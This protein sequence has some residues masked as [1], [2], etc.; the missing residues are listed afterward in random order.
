MHFAQDFSPKHN[1]KI[2]IIIYLTK[3]FLKKSFCEGEIYKKSCLIIDFD[4][5][6][7]QHFSLLYTIS[8]SNVL[9][10]DNM[11]GHKG[12][13]PSSPSKNLNTFQIFWADF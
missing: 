13:C 11:A 1:A 8:R 10:N 3:F 9:Q 6:C 4:N 12:A 7:G 5:I 2:S